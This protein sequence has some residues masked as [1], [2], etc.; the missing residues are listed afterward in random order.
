ME[1][2]RYAHVPLAA[3]SVL[4]LL[5]VITGLVGHG[6]GGWTLPWHFGPPAPGDD[7]LDDVRI[8]FGDPAQRSY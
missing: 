2:S 1:G 7:A 5:G 6:V 4:L 3:V 8:A